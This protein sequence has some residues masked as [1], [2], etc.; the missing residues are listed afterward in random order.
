MGSMVRNSIP[1]RREGEFSLGLSSLLYNGYQ[2]FLQKIKRLGRGAKHSP[3][4]RA[5]VVKGQNYTY[6]PPLCLQ[7]MLVGPF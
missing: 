1:G 4:Y 5:V 7:G 3:T 6:T 2:V